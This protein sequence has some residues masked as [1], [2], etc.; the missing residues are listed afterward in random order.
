MTPLDV[1]SSVD[2]GDHIL[3]FSV[4]VDPFK[5]V[6]SPDKLVLVPF[7][8]LSGG[9]LGEETLVGVSAERTFGLLRLLWLG[10]WLGWLL[11]FV[12]LHR[13]ILIVVIY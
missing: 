8:G 7:L 3:L 6:L 9:I 11:F 4:L 12:R 10:F 13:L 1:K 5:F 2:S